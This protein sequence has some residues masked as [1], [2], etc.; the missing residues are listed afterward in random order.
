[1]EDGK[2]RC[3]TVGFYLRD[4][5]A[6]REVALKLAQ[7]K[8][9]E[10]HVVQSRMAGP[11]ELGL[12]DLDNVILY[13]D[14]TSDE[15]LRDMYQNSHVLFLPLIQSTANNALL[16]GLSCGLPIVSTLLPSIQAYVPQEAAFLI[17]QN[18]PNQL[19]RAILYLY[20]NND[21]RKKMGR[22]SRERA[23]E[24]D[25]KRITPLYEDVYKQL[26]ET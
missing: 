8:N 3:I 1:M 10:F 25:W 22:K 6:I 16:E 18:N 7:Y 15:A 5:K 12:E 17:E 23:L 20:E 21:E 19:A 24:L 9:I 4:F 26:I 2:F 14:T 13:R 11:K